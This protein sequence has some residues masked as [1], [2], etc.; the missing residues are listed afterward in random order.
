MNFHRIHS[1]EFHANSNFVHLAQ[2]SC[3]GS[4]TWLVTPSTSGCHC[5]S[6]HSIRPV[7]SSSSG[8]P[9]ALLILLF[10]S[11]SVLVHSLTA[12]LVVR[13]P[14]FSSNYGIRQKLPHACWWPSW[15][16][17]LHFLGKQDGFM[18]SFFPPCSHQLYYCFHQ[19]QFLLYKASCLGFIFTTTLYPSTFPTFHFVPIWPL[20]SSWLL[21]TWL[22]FWQHQSWA[23]LI[24]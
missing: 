15:Y 7:T 18:L 1:G 21:S 24:D 12:P 23:G 3:A 11:G 16:F 8:C 17:P 22:P 4:L 10:N 6:P 2:Q 14:S 5:F 20:I 13:L 19:L 9:A